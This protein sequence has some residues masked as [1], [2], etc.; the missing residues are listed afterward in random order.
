[1]HLSV[2]I[3]AYNESQTLKEKVS[4]YNQYLSRQNYDYEIIIVNDGSLDDTAEIAKGLENE[5]NSIRFIDNQ[6]NRGK[7]AA[8]K[9][10]FQNATGNYQL[11]IDADGATSIDHLNQV[12][13]HFQNGADLVIGTRNSLDADGAWQKIKQPFWKRSFGKFGN[14]IIQTLTV[15]GIWDT[16]CGFKI[17]KA[18]A[19]NKI[20]PQQT[21]NRWAFDVELLVIAR[22]KN[23]NIAKVPVVWKN[24]KLSRVGIRGYF[25][26]LKEILKI[27]WN[28]IL[29]KYN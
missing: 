1:M 23:Q 28:K 25:T 22:K 5:V 29:G 12:W 7:G 11:F 6:I 14:L 27:F 2:I 24:S 21:I 4:E 20:V 16:Q 18:E 19:I 13:E 17:F 26:S 10:G 3:P 9:Q 15:P 8:V